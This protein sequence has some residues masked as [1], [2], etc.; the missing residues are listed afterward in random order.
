MKASGMIAPYEHEQPASNVGL[1]SRYGALLVAW[2]ATCG[3]L[4]FSEVLGWAPCIMCWYQRILMYPLSLILAIGILRRDS[5]LHQYVLPF[6]LVGAC[7]SLYHY[8]LIKTTWLPEPACS[9]SVPC[10]VDY[11]NWLGFINIPLLAFTAFIL[12]SIC[13]FV[14]A[15][16]PV[17]EAESSSPFA[18]ENVLVYAIIGIVLIWFVVAGR[19]IA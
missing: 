4:F 14:F 16:R 2:I 19:L 18:L 13:A 3:S 6:S 12:I 5:K 8:L 1:Y 11:I 10:N 15:R 9:V 17:A 7:V